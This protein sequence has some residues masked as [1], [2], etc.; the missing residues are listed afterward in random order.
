MTALYV[1]MEK[2]YT[3]EIVICIVMNAL[4]VIVK[5]WDGSDLNL[6]ILGLS[7]WTDFGAKF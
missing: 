3:E 5:T 2:T 1:S 7:N 6:G 4:D